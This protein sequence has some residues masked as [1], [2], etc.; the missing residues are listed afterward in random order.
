MPA[1]TSAGEVET[2][3]AAAGL[4]FSKGAEPET[5]IRFCTEA[6]ASRLLSDGALANAH[7]RRAFAF[8]RQHRLMK[9]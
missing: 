9:P 7:Y 4:C 1:H 5:L 2:A 3:K 6:I 8:H